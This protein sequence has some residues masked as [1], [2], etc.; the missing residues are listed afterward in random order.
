MRLGHDPR[1]ARE[2]YDAMLQLKELN[3]VT[4][5]RAYV[6]PLA[7]TADIDLDTEVGRFDRKK[8]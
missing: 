2:V 8:K 3:Y 1:L 7:R 6:K 5:L 4:W